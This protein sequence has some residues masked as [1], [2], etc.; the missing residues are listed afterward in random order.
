ML[1]EAETISLASDE[2]RENTAELEL[3]LAE[4]ECDVTLGYGETGVGRIEVSIEQE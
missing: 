4:Q 2:G 1:L 3:G